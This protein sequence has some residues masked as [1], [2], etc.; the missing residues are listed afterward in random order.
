[1]KDDQWVR[2]SDCIWHETV[3]VGNYV[4]IADM[5]PDLKDFFVT[6]LCVATVTDVFMMDQLAEAAAKQSK[7]ADEIKRLMLSAS[8]L[9]SP[10]TN[11]SEIQMS[12][13]VLQQ[14]K[15]LPCRSL[16]GGIHFCSAKDTFFIL[17]NKFFGRMFEG[18]LVMLDCTYEELNSLHELFRILRLDDHYLARH[19][20]EETSAESSDMSDMLTDEFRECAYAISW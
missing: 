5:Y 17:D 14:S 7:S 4:P 13:E 9:L 11:M 16:T 2:P 15:Y 20:S 19:V 12:I 6:I 18:K 8:T 10:N 3:E 1:M